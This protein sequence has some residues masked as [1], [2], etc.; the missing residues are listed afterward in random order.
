M[1]AAAKALETLEEGMKAP[2]EEPRQA[3]QL[4]QVQGYRILVSPLGV[5]QKTAGGIWKPDQLVDLEQTAH[6]CGLVVGMGEDCY[7]D[8]DRFQS[9]WCKEGDFVLMGAYKGTRFA[10]H[11]REFRIINDD[12]VL[13][14]VED[15]R[16][17]TR[18]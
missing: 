6:V 10:I 15:P 12:Q 1:S 8:K 2:D 16:G 14:V 9:A 3:T 4:P 11:G 13:A 5:E 18:A 7:K 17:Y